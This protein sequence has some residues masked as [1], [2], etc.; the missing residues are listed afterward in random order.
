MGLGDSVVQA[1]YSYTMAP[2]PSLISEDRHATVLPFVM[3]GDYDQ[4]NGNV[5][6]VMDLVREADGVGGFEVLQAGSS[7]I[8]HDFTAI[9]EGDALKGEM[10]GIGVALVILVLVF[11]ALVAAGSP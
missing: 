1:G 2:D 4:A 6:K 7:S 5:V 10:F 11:G 3:A 8:G 9:A